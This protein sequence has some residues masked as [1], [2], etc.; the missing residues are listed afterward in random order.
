MTHNRYSTT[1]SSTFN[2]RMLPD[3]SS[4]YPPDLRADSISPCF[5]LLSL[6]CLIVAQ[7]VHFLLTALLL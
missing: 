3:Y 1:A 5:L 7:L 4:L 6:A 2:V